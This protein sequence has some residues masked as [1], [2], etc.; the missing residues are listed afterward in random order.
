MGEIL[1][2]YVDTIPDDDYQRRQQQL[3]ALSRSLSG[4]FG[5][6]PDEK[7]G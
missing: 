5:G 7:R 2:I 4:I 3:G 6:A 1:N